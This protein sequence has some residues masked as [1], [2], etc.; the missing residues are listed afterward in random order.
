VQFASFILYIKA[1][2]RGSIEAIRRRI[3]CQEWDNMT[4]C[5]NQV[6]HIHTTNLYYELVLLSCPTFIEVPNSTTKEQYSFS[7]HSQC[8]RE[9]TTVRESMREFRRDP[10]GEMVKLFNYYSVNSEDIY[11]ISYISYINKYFSDVPLNPCLHWSSQTW[12]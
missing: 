7:F 10:T 4:Q 11:Y 2:R 1:K 9:S 5:D 3:A 6:S 8:R 12:R